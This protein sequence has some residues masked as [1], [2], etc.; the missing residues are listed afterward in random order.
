MNSLLS[1]LAQSG[2]NIEWGNIIYILIFVAISAAGGITE[3]YK[4]RTQKKAAEGEEDIAVAV[5]EDEEWI[6]LTP[7]QKTK[8]VVKPQPAATVTPKPKQAPAP[9]EQVYIPIPVSDPLPPR[10]PQQPQ[11]ARPARQS[12][13]VSRS[14]TGAK[15]QTD[16]RKKTV[17]TKTGRPAVKPECEIKLDP[18]KLTPQKLREAIVL[19]EILS[20][21]LALRKSGQSMFDPPD[22]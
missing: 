3:W 10:K 7:P 11:P 15:R 19:S 13:T 22:C 16:P 5:V 18:E 8:T 4:K 2:P 21:P 14:L 12:K 9:V 17:T 6:E 20:P 1:I